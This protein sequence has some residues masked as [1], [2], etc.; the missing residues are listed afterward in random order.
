MHTLPSSD[1][2]YADLGELLEKA[3][4]RGF[5]TLEEIHE[6][7]HNEGDSPTEIIP[8]L[9]A[10]GIEIFSET[11]FDED[12]SADFSEEDE[13]LPDLSDVPT[14]DSVGLYLKEMACVPLLSL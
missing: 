14:D 6:F 7:A 4:L 3:E 13:V 5:L 1:D 2:P 10:A 12:E 8:L 11:Y 9:Q